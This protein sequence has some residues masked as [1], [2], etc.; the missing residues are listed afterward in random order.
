MAALNHD[1][2]YAM[3]VTSPLI[4][5]LGGMG[6]QAGLDMAEKLVMETL[7]EKDQDHLPFLLYSL[8]ASVPDRT[9]FLL[10][11]TAENPAFAIADQFEAMARAGVKL[12]AMACNTAH[13]RP[14]F[15]VVL[16]LLD[17]RHV[18][19]RIYHLV[20]EKIGRAHV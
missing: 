16:D 1:C 6:P 11:I 12:A 14:I 20:N 13:A 5:I 2:R 18:D 19:L 3:K 4:G 9:E 15:D 8:P 10:G 7:T 17:Q